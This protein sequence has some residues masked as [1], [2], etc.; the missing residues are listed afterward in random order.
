MGFLT[1]TV[2]FERFRIEEDPTGA[3]GESH[4]KKLEKNRIG[5]FETNLFEQPDVGFIGGAHLLDADFSIEKNIIGEAMHFGIRVDSV[6]VP[7]SIKNAWMQIELAPFLVD[8]PGGKPSK[9]QKQEAKDAVDA[10]CAAEADQGNFKRMAETS[11]LLSLIH[12]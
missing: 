7:S 8:N 12:I 6:A 5:A 10:K 3:F 11:V 1:G 9:A 4:I 2:T